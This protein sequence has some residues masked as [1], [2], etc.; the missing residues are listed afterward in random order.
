[1]LMAT[2][3][4]EMAKWQKKRLNLNEKDTEIK[5]ILG[6]FLKSKIRVEIMSKGF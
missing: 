1:M 5:N 4:V 2:T 6:G 3:E